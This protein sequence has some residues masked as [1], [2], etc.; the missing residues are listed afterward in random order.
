MLKHA[1]RDFIHFADHQM[2]V[3]TH[4]EITARHNCL[5]NVDIYVLYHTCPRPLS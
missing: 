4:G 5:V 1:V 2:S 3:F